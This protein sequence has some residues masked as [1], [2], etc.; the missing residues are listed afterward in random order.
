M[1]FPRKRHAD[2]F[3]PLLPSKAANNRGKDAVHWQLL[4]PKGANIPHGSANQI[5]Q[6]NVTRNGTLKSSAQPWKIETT[7]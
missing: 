7:A 3:A 1:S 6:K 4:P 2:G 5:V